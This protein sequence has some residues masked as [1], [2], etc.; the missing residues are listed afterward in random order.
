M[1]RFVFIF[2]NV[3]KLRFFLVILR[4][5]GYMLSGEWLFMRFVCFLWWFLM[6][7]IFLCMLM[8]VFVIFLFKL[9]FVY[10]ILMRF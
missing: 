4:D 3:I 2:G 9:K 5:C 10:L 1:F 6:V 7:V 8:D